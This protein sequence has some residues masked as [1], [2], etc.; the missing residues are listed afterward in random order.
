MS[1]YDDSPLA[2]DIFE[3]NNF[4]FYPNPTRD[5]VNL[6]LNQEITNVTV[7]NLLG[8]QVINQSV[9]GNQ[10]QIDMSGLS[11]GAYLVKVT[12]GNQSKTVKVVRE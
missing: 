1:T 11:K 9:A 8:Q 5:I 2:I 4:A 10:V 6:S 7:L 3:T 12:A